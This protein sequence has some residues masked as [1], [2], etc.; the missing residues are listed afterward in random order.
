LPANWRAYLA[1]YLGLTG[2]LMRRTVDFGIDLG[3]TNSAIAVMDQGKV[4]I[5]KSSG[6]A[7][8]EIIPSVIRIDPEGRVITGQSAY[9]QLYHDPNNTAASFKLLLG[10]QQ[11]KKFLHSQR[12]LKPEELSAE[13]LR[14]LKARVRECMPEEPELTSAVITVPCYFEM[15]QSQATAKAA[16]LAGIDFAPLL[17]EPIAA[18]IAYGFLE[19]MPKGYWIVYDLGGGTFDV[20]LLSALDGHLMVIDH[21]GDNYLGGNDFDW[22]IVE[23]VIYP[24]LRQEFDLPDLGRSP[25]YSFLNALLKY[26]AEKAKI[27]LSQVE[28]TE[29]VIEGGDR[30]KDQRGKTINL[31]IPFTRH[32]LN[33]VI[34][35]DIERSFRIF[36]QVL[37]NQN[38]SAADVNH[39]ILVGGPT[40]I[41]Y[42]RQR[43]K[44]E[45][46]IPID[47]FV[48]PM[49]VV[50]KG[51]AIYAA[52]QLLPVIKT[53]KPVDSGP[54]SV[55]ID[56]K[57]EPMTTSLQAS[58]A[59]K[60]SN[61]GHQVLP[62][63]TKVQIRSAAGDWQSGMIETK[64][65]AFFASVTLR[66]S[67][68][69]LFI[70]SLF[71]PDGQHIPVE[72]DSFSIH[73]GMSV[74][75]PPLARSIGVELNNGSFDRL[76]NKGISLPAKASFTYHAAHDLHPGRE[77]NVLEIP[78]REGESD[79]F[80]QNRHLGSLVIRGT[81]VHR[82]I[83]VNSE[84]E[85]TLFVDQSRAVSAEAYIPVV[86]Q[87]FSMRIPNM[88]S[89]L[90]DIQ[91][92][93]AVLEREEKRWRELQDKALS[94]EMALG[95]AMAIVNGSFAEIRREIDAALGGDQIAVEKADRRLKD[96]QSHLDLT[97][98]AF[99]WPS[100][101]KEQKVVL[102]DVQDTVESWGRSGDFAS[103]FELLKKDLDKAITLKD[104]KRLQKA[105]DEMHDLKW[106]ILF[107][108]KE[109]WIGAF[110]ELR[111]K[112][113][114]RFV[115]QKRAKELLDE[116]AR[117]LA[118]QDTE[119]VQSITI[120]LW[121]LISRDEQQNITQTVNSR[122]GIKR[123]NS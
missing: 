76:L 87:K 89:P 12:L 52:S 79:R 108:Q 103:R 5:L 56:L 69:N 23:E 54:N 28:I 30:I 97:Q 61:A 118:R 53:A 36:R 73:Q 94:L 43:L 49:T 63:G 2:G 45:F 77:D 42:V 98:K 114:S 33:C 81:D 39:L 8:S 120:E 84:I 9:D 57:Y 64:N 25:Q 13:V 70:I 123:K 105:L 47:N 27:N 68:I 113:V 62:A 7:N 74:G 11:N 46:G 116:G 14:N 40:H 51:A 101:L 71:A 67:Q 20:A 21:G 16:K 29:I 83:P 112:E 99:L 22:R 111:Q 95:E 93:R 26:A 24:V 66:E 4:R 107:R 96:L 32:Q 119:S 117:A 10:T 3:T 34:A 109:F 15:T 48:D 55:T 6:S 1:L 106:E 110:Q 104:A 41:P 38:L 72:S 115:D 102:A 91:D 44:D 37:K 100:L 75:A 65:N 78:V 82:K 60:I 18:S 58:V 88:T 19:K 17:Q 59:G 31:R 92:L 80:D 122:S 90:P 85:V 121:K 50:A 86:D 35:D